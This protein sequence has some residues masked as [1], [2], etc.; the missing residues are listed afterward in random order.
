ME[1]GLER[2]YAALENRQISRDAL[3]EVATR[4]GFER[5][6]RHS[7]NAAL[8][9]HDS[10]PVMHR[11]IKDV[12]RLMLGIVALYMDATGG[13]THRRLRVVTGDVGLLSAGR[14]TAILWQLQ[15]IGYV[16]AESARMSGRSH[17]YIPTESMRRAF[18][19]RFRVEL[20]A[21][22]QIDPSI[23]PAVANIHSPTFFSG[24]IAEMGKLALDAVRNPQP[25]L[26]PLSN[27]GE[28][29]AGMLVL[30][31]LLSAADTGEHF[32]PVGPVSFSVPSLSKRFGVSR[33]HIRRLL[34]EL[35]QV[36][37]F[38]SG[39]IEGSGFLEA[40]L[41]TA[42]SEMLAFGYIGHAACAHVAFQ[43]G[44]SVNAVA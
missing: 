5:A 40:P 8:A 16:V 38:R 31:A 25:A 14:A 6:L 41:A 30:Y 11:N 13:L 4:P 10:D 42:L 9:L 22:A 39:S 29:T 17:R 7:V 34:R 3:N 27:Y 26:N 37:Y 23:A 2:W 28:R 20:E 12:G 21:M 36:G 15:G 44:D 24:F 43:A 33:T 19:A 35:E 32:P 1:T 18:A